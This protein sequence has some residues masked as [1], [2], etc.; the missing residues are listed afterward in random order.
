MMKTLFTSSISIEININ[1]N[2]NK[3]GIETSFENREYTVHTCALNIVKDVLNNENEL[4]QSPNYVT[5]QV[6]AS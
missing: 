6:T 1:S 2:H 4:V 5:E 3:C